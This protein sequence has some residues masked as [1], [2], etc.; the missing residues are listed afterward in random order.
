MKLPNSGEIWGQ[1]KAQLSANNGE[2]LWKNQKDK[3]NWN[4]FINL[5]I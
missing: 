5:L 2:R 3:D 4:P 1:R